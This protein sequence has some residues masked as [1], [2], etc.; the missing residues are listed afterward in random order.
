M[1][2]KNVL[3]VALCFAACITTLVPCAFGQGSERLDQILAAMDRNAKS[4]RSAQAV[5]TAKMW[6]SVINDFVPPPDIGKIFLRKS[7][8]GIEAS[9]IY[10]QPPD[11][12]I[13]FSGNRLEIYMNGQINA[14]DASAHHDELETF[15][16]L[17]FGSSG[18]DMRNS[19]DIKDLGPDK[20]ESFDTEK[21]ELVPKSASVLT[22]VP[23]IILWMDPK[24]GISRQEQIYVE[25]DGDYRLAQYTDIELNR[26]LPKNAFKMKASTK[27][28]TH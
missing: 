2:T 21:L 16:V 18:E 17:G 14:Y 22:H 7:D 1:A 26:N 15:L 3:R 9:A 19:Y 20:V 23:K 6:N 10:Q 25:R 4:F 13:M 8:A 5:F 24:L 28:I 12:M 27:T 11:K